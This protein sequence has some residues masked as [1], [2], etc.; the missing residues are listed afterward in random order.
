MCCR[1]TC[2]TSIKGEKMK[3][4]IK[5][6]IFII[7]I[8]LIMAV[9]IAL[10]VITHNKDKPGDLTTGKV[11]ASQTNAPQKIKIGM[12][13]VA[14]LLQLF[15]AIDK[16]YFAEENLIVEPIEMSGG[17]LIAQAVASGDLQ[18]GFSNTVSIII[19]H[20]K[21]FDFK[22]IAPGS[23][24]N[25][26]TKQT[27]HALVVRENSKISKPRDLEGKT[28]AINALGN[29]NELVIKAWTE[30]NNVDMNKIKLVELPFPNME[31]ALEKGQIDAAIMTEPFITL[32]KQ[33]RAIK[34]LD[35]DPFNVISDR[36]MITGWFA[37]ESWINNNP[38]TIASF[39]RAIDKA[40]V[41]I[42]DHP[43]EM[44]NILKKY[45]KLNGSLAEE[46]ALGEF[47]SEIYRED[48]DKTIYVAEKYGFIGKSFEIEEILGG[49]LH[50]ED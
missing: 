8:M 9:A 25:S 28:I 30:K 40:T 14:D 32:S 19:A 47:S 13:P 10:I 21:G 20:E 24:S 12:A 33:H 5:I 46:I 37:K 7:A 1:E 38:Q 6:K 43:E 15:V 49:D 16:D 18:I 41:Y 36:L 45:T 17:P 42:N 26:V 35:T 39:K 2:S 44:S 50:V 48:I 31:A 11:T 23:F 34:I 27:V 22:Y 4:E 3:K 29:I